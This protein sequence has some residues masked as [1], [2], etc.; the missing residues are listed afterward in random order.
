MTQRQMNAEEL[1]TILDCHEQ[2]DEEGMGE[3]FTMGSDEEFGAEDSDSEDSEGLDWESEDVV[4]GKS[5]K[6]C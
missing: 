4:C 1:L 5:N 6:I 3:I 2:Q